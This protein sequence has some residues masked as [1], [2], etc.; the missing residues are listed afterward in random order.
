MDRAMP[1]VGRPRIASVRFSPPRRARSEARLREGA[2]VLISASVAR[3]GGP[4]SMPGHRHDTGRYR[5]PG[6]GQPMD[7]PHE[8]GATMPT[9][10]FQT[11]RLCRGR[12]ASPSEGACVME[13]AS[14]LAGER[15]TDHP[16]AVCPVIAT[17]LR[18]YNDGIDDERREDLYTYAAAAVGTRERG[19]RRARAERFGEFFSC[20]T[21]RWWGSRL[22]KLALTALE[23]ARDD[24]D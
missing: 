23:Y 13:L 1:N 4:P 20:P 17:V 19:L 2:V 14:M 18:A 10:T 24:D 21:L 9:P 5:R 8:K 22:R 3:A 11:T 15:F 7:R 16:R 6:G 12:H